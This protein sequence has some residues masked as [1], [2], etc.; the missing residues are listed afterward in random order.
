MLGLRSPTL[1]P[2]ASLALPSVKNAI[3]QHL[4]SLTSAHRPRSADL[5]YAVFDP[6]QDN[7]PFNDHP[8]GSEAWYTH[9][10]T[11][12]FW[13][14]ARP[15]SA[16]T[17]N[18][19]PSAHAQTKEVYEELVRQL[20][21][22]NDAFSELHANQASKVDLQALARRVLPEST[23]D[24]GQLD[25]RPSGK[26]AKAA[27]FAG[28]YAHLQ[29]RSGRN[30]VRDILDHVEDDG[31]EV[32]GKVR[33]IRTWG[34]SALLVMR[35]YMKELE[36][37]VSDGAKRRSDLFSENLKNFDALAEQIE[38]L[39]NLRDQEEAWS[40]YDEQLDLALAAAEDGHDLERT[41]DWVSSAADPHDHSRD[42]V[43]DDRSDRVDEL[44]AD[45]RRNRRFT[46]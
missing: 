12:G 27:A 34:E 14:D 13:V 2:A 38:A 44:D 21:G 20:Q 45:E 31:Y 11:T 15:F 6:R 23:M 8:I 28:L 17:E 4:R 46:R 30:F 41:R 22:I 25:N 9:G 19:S 39:P 37:P 16:L 24:E 7:V 33:R 40:H 1:S 18:L 26:D 36:L 42:D 3:D 29:Y 10:T 5:T 43:S 35:D 32:G